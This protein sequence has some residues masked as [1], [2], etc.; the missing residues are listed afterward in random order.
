MAQATEHI[1]LQA[2]DI[3]CGHCVASIQDRLGGLDGIEKVSA[4]AETKLVDIDF[5]PAK[6]DLAKIESELEDEGYP[7]SK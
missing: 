6:V 3:S 5:D 4:S 2:P 1:T 7:V